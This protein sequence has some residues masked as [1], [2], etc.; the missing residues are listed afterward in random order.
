M[1][2][3]AAKK[4]KIRKWVIPAAI[5]VVG[6]AAA[7]IL[8]KVLK[9]KSDYAT[10]TFTDTTVLE[11]TDLESTVSATGTVESADSRKV[12][13]TMA[14]PVL[15]VFVEVGDVVTEGQ[16]LAQ[17]DG[18]TLENQIETQR[19]SME[20]QQKAASAQVQ[21]ALDN[22]TSFKEGVD[23]GLNTTMLSARTQ[24]DNALKAY[25][26]AV[27]A[28]NDYNDSLNDGSNTTIRSAKNAL[29]GAIAARDAAEEALNDYN[30]GLELVENYLQQQYDSACSACDNAGMAYD[31]AMKA[32]YDQLDAL[33]TAR[34]NAYDNYQTAQESVS[35]A[36]KGV[37]DQLKAYQNN[38]NTAS[39]GSSTAVSEESIRQLEEALDDTKITAPCA[40]TVTAVY[41][42]VGSTG[43][44]LLFV[45]E[46]TNH[47]IINTTV[48][49][50]DLGSVKEGMAV[51]IRSDATGD[52]RYDGIISSIAP[53]ARKT[54]YGTTDITGDAVFETEVR[55][56]SPETGLR[57]GLEA[58]MDFILA[59]ES[60]VLTVPYD[61]VYE[62]A[63]GQS[64][65]MTA[66]EQT[67]GTWLLAELPV[68]TGTSDDLD[69][70]VSGEGVT[71]GLRIINEPE[72]MLDSLGK[73]ITIG[74]QS[75][76][77]VYGAYMMGGL[78]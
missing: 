76:R 30:G 15:E 44:G 74:E 75:I 22:Y 34:N 48:K 43:T 64:C 67:D 68:L 32:A 1:A 65:I 60:A 20:T 54:A 2:N 62:N 24:A 27:D 69:I 50:Y 39:A 47:L 78:D 19:I 9:T 49:G 13:S 6:A 18:S 36:R 21:S 25:N 10:L 58:Q 33:E 31:S 63:D 73:T 42:T 77:S 35:A 51:R 40:G 23:Q 57:I 52:A 46:D 66:T 38:Y 61:A 71:K 53:T 72:K 8:P 56:T 29:D 41:A 26:S 5:V 7:I 55:V 28:Y 16:L 59:E 14:Y 11:S 12:Y 3:T 37:Q 17:L 45:I 70:A 4:K